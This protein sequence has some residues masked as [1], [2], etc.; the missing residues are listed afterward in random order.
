MLFDRNAEHLAGASAVNVAAGLEQIKPPLLSG[1]PGNDPGLDR[2]EVRNI[3]Q[4]AFRRYES[5]TDQLAERV[6]HVTEHFFHAL[7]VPG[8]DEFPRGFQVCEVVLG[9]VLQLNQTA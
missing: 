7:V 8:A 1:K 3:K 6:R 2:R 5:G 4:L 9:Q